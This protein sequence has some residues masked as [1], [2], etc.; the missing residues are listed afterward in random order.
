MKSIIKKICACALVVCLL[1]CII[2]CKNKKGPTSSS[3]GSDVVDTP[4]QE[5]IASTDI[6][7]VNNGVS[8]YSV[9]MPE[10]ATEA[11]KYAVKILNEQFERATGT[12]LPVATD[13]GQALNTN[14]KV[15][16]VGRTSILANSGL[17]VTQE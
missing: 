10:N 7:L 17:S 4:T 14:N 9:V 12:N 8:E 16:S 5:N 3:G 13:N 2:T 15:I 6:L 1:F 11:E